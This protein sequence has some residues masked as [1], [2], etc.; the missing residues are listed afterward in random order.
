MT[1]KNLNKNLTLL[2]KKVLNMGED[3]GGII[4]DFILSEL[5]AGS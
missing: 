3:W 5:N 1:L 4:I 2:E